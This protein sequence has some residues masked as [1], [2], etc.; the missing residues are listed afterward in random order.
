MAENEQIKICP[1]CAESIKAAAKVCPHCRKLQGR[2]FCIS[3]SDLHA[4]LA[5]ALFILS[6]F[7]AF[8]FFGSSRQYSPARHKILVLNKQFG[9]ETTSDHTNVVVSGVLTNASDYTWKLTGFEIR[10]LDAAGKII[11]TDHAGSE[12]MD[13]TVL[14]HDECSFHLNLPFREKVP[15]FAASKVT[16]TEAKE[17]GFW[18]NN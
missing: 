8:Y 1:L 17:P 9:I 16:V 5:V 11:D 4:I 6:T 2:F 3:Q 10:F 18:F 12:Y 15:A 13:L 14:P 7:L